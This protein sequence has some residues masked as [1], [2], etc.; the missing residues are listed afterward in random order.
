MTKRIRISGAVQQAKCVQPRV[1]HAWVAGFVAKTGHWA[2]LT[3]KLIR[4]NDSIGALRANMTA[5]LIRIN[6][7][8]GALRTL[9]RTSGGYLGN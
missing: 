4:I 2:N 3:A 6:D 9:F 7:S 1:N 5:K 8:I